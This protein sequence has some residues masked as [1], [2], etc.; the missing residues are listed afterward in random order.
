MRQ[1]AKVGLGHRGVSLR[2][3]WLLRWLLPLEKELLKELALV[4]R[5]RLLILVEA[6]GLLLLLGHL[7]AL[8]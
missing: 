5:L 7:L 6:L 4:E 2:G 3:R 1:V 8:Q